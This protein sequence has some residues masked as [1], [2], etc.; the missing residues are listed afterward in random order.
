MPGESARARG[1]A[2]RP[3]TKCRGLLAYLSHT[4]LVIA[5]RYAAPAHNC[6]RVLRVLSQA[7]PGQSVRSEKWTCRPEPDLV[8]E[9]TDNFGNRRLLMGHRRIAEEFLFE[10]E[11]EV[12][13]GPVAVPIDRAQP[14]DLFLRPT[15][16][17]DWPAFVTDLAAAARR[18]FRG[19]PAR[20]AEHLNQVARETLRYTHHPLPDPLPVSG[21]LE[22]GTG[23]CQDFAHLHLALCRAANLPA[24]YVAG[25]NPAEGLMHAWTEVLVGKSWI[26][27]D[28]THGRGPSLGCVVVAVGRDFRDARPVSGVYRGGE[29]ALKMHC[30]TEAVP[31]QGDACESNAI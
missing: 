8:R 27:F 2:W 12:E 25:Y 24:R 10:L 11:T 3:D 26:G 4:H 14:L 17:A 29:A 21:T 7:R 16:L 15:A 18:R 6:R 31:A 13:T 9:A 5:V 20:L 23:S 19:S 1:R 28:P 22:A 30:R